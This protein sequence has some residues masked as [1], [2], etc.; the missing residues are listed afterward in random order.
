M[1]S[2][3]FITKRDESLSCDGDDDDFDTPKS[4]VHSRT[5]TDAACNRGYASRSIKEASDEAFTQC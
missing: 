3:L 4:T 2:Y 5:I 1:F